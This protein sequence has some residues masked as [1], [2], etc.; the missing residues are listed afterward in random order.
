MIR[1]QTLPKVAEFNYSV[2]ISQLYS[3]K[4]ARR[5]G[6]TL[7]SSRITMRLRRISFHLCWPQ[8]SK[9]L[10]GAVGVVLSLAFGCRWLACAR[11]CALFTPARCIFPIPR[12]G[13]ACERS[14]EMPGCCSAPNCRSNYA[15]QPNVRVHVFPN[16]PV[17]RAAWTRAVPRKDFAPTKNTVV[18]YGL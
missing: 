9:L 16:D 17:R 14:A 11:A 6:K 13:C 3:E 10:V 7:L 18:R 4:M 2:S 5:I 12:C 1:A 8:W 15:G